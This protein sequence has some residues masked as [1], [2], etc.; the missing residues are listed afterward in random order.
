[1]IES[2]TIPT[3]TTVS[4][5]GTAISI[6]TEYVTVGLPDTIVAFI[7]NLV[8][9]KDGIN[10]I[11]GELVITMKN[12]PNVDFS[13]DVDGNLIISS[14]EGDASNYSLDSNGNLI[15]SS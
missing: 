5:I 14:L 3:Q 11:E 4:M 7:A 15:Y 13:I 10:Y 12:Y 6:C 9:N 1:M 2:K 8:G